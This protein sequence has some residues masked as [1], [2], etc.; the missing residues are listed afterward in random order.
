MKDRFLYEITR[1]N[2]KI[3]RGVF[4]IGEKK[5]SRKNAEGGDTRDE[6]RTS[7]QGKLEMC[8]AEKAKTE[9]QR[10]AGRAQGCT[11]YRLSITGHR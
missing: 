7:R 1:E 6:E 9:L 10:T 8:E 2:P 3:L 4:L 5:L 11:A